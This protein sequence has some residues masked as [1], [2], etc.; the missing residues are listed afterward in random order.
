MDD[1]D[2]Q[3]LMQFACDIYCKTFHNKFG[4]YPYKSDKWNHKNYEQIVKL[5]SKNNFDIEDYILG[6]FY[7]IDK[8]IIYMTPRD[9]TT[10]EAIDRYKK[11]KSSTNP[12]MAEY[13]YEQELKLLNIS[14]TNAPHLYNNERDVLINQFTPLSSWFRV[15]YL[16]TFDEKLFDLYGK[17]AWE[18][19]YVSPQLR[20]YLRRM[21]CNN[22]KELE[23]RVAVFAD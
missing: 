23:K 16:D 2:L 10:K 3:A 18:E 20:K 17:R 13:L 12:L 7:T 21:H 8:E 15:L 14:L 19:L 9:L 1:I 4:K 22:F 5:C 6:S 11:F